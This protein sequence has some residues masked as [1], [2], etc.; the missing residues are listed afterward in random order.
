M[1]MTVSDRSR[2][3]KEFLKDQGLE[4]IISPAQAPMSLG[5]VLKSLQFLSPQEDIR[6]LRHQDRHQGLASYS[7]R[8]KTDRSTKC[9]DVGSL[10]EKHLVK[11]S[12]QD[13][14]QS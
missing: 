6:H 1:I 9:P 4:R 3:V 8:E 10:R 2:L 7:K 12:P 13:S 5:S 11:S 14:P